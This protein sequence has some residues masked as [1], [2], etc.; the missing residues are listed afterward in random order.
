MM[1]KLIL[2]LAVLFS[3]LSGFSQDY[4]QITSDAFAKV[5]SPYFDDFNF[6]Y[7]KGVFNSV[8]L[9]FNLFGWTRYY[10]G[11]NCPRE[12]TGIA[13]VSDE[14]YP[15]AKKGASAI[16]KLL[17]EEA[18]KTKVQTSIYVGRMLSGTSPMIFRVSSKTDDNLFF[19]IK[20]TDQEIFGVP[21][22]QVDKKKM[23][24]SIVDHLN[25]MNKDKPRMIIHMSDD[26]NWLLYSYKRTEKYYRQDE[27]F[28]IAQQF[29]ADLFAATKQKYFENGYFYL[30]VPFGMGIMVEVSN[31][32][33]HETAREWITPE[34]VRECCFE[35]GHKYHGPYLNSWF[36]K[37]QGAGNAVVREYSDAF[38]IDLWCTWYDLLGGEWTP[39]RITSMIKDAR[40]DSA[41]P[42]NEIIDRCKSTG[43]PLQIGIN[44]RFGLRFCGPVDIDEL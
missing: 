21:F 19:D 41:S 23:L 4:D 26:D 33:S 37:L 22:D 42:M 16:R 10:H 12:V 18:K 9:E 3:A 11:Q 44:S 14:E 30:A 29:S 8:Y 20:V 7:K 27:A 40:K 38:T 17:L 1:K 5:L 25:M 24:H 35:E 15:M 39:E 6:F 43:K 36:L 2:T 34:E 28:R 13:W 31:Q 32:D